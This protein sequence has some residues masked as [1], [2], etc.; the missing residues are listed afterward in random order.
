ML[1]CRYVSLCSDLTL[2]RRYV[3]FSRL[4]HYH[5]CYGSFLCLW[6]C[7]VS[8]CSNLSMKR[9]V[10]TCS[11][12]CVAWGQMP[13]ASCWC[14][15]VSAAFVGVCLEVSSFHSGCYMLCSA[16]ARLISFIYAV[17]LES[18]GF[19]Y[20]IILVAAPFSVPPTEVD[21]LLMLCFVLQ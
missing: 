10:G 16:L 17:V 6:Q 1:C 11:L 9:H 21:I 4:S 12:L 14:F 7:Y 18:F 19:I 3:C 20:V 2:Q 5:L 13:F 8:F 15:A